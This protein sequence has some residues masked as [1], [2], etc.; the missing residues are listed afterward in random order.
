MPEQF[1]AQRLEQAQ[2]AVGAGGDPEQHRTDQTVA[3]FLG[4][5]VEH[6][7]A[8]RRNVLEQLLHQLVVVVGERLQHGEAR[9]LLAVEILALERNDLGRRLFAVDIG[10]LEREVDVTG[11]DLVLPDRDLA[12]QQRHA[13]GRLQQLDGIANAL[14]GL[15][16]L[17]EKQ[18][19]GNLQLFELAQDQLQLRHLALVGL[20]HDHR[21]VDRRQ[22]GA[23]VVDEFDRT[24]T[25]DEGVVVAHEG[26]GGD[27]KLD[28]HLVVARFLAGVADRRARI[29]RALALDR[30]GAGE[31]GFEQRCLAALERTHKCNAP[32]APW[33]A[34]VVSHEC[35]PRNSRSGLSGPSGL[36]FQGRMR[37]AS[38]LEF[39]LVAAARRP[40]RT[41]GYVVHPS[42]QRLSEMASPAICIVGNAVPCVGAQTLATVGVAGVGEMPTGTCLAERSSPSSIREQFDPPASTQVYVFGAPRPRKRRRSR[43]SVARN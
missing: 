38:V 7:V 10:A 27:R 19:A 29:R 39:R 20:A 34:A 3:L 22:G 24:R 8:R 43:D 42:C 25:I 16:D 21:R 9:F 30:A 23:H 2:D 18:K 40:C 17:V 15:V 12:Q 32:W 28:A 37:M 4:E 14:V 36:S 33:S 11:D 26:R 35:L 6:L 41:A 13:R 31:Y 5:V 1:V